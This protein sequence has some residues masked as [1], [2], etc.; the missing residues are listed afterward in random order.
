MQKGIY[1]QFAKDLVARLSAVKVG[2]PADPSVEMGPCVRE[3]DAME[4]ERQINLTVEQGGELLLGGKR[5]G[6]FVEPT[7]IKTPKSADIAKDMECFGPVWP[8]IPFDTLDEAVEIANNTIFGLSSGVITSDIRVAM[9]VANRVESGSCVIGGSGNYRLA[10]QP[11]G[12]YKYSGVGREGAV[13]TLDEVTQQK[14]IAFKGVLN[15]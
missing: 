8:L 4:V 3:A 13:S 5:K 9:K 7:V 15:D 2:N 11:F 14:T 12:G 10:H 1:D 6:A